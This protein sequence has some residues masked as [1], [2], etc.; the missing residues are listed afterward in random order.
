MKYL[1][2][3]LIS[4]LILGQATAQ[5][6]AWD[7]TR[8]KNWPAG[9][10]RIQITASAD[11][12]PQPC[13]VYRAS[14]PNQ[15]LVVSL[16]SWSGDYA[17]ADSL[18]WEIR[19]RD[20]NYIHPHF[21]GPNWTS[22]ACGS[23]LVVQD[24]DDAIRFAIRELKANP[25]EVHVVGAS[26]GG[27]AAMLCYLQLTYP[28]KSISSWVGISSLP[29][30]YDESL[31]RGQ[32]YA[33]D[34]L[35]ATGD[36]LQLNV[37]EAQKRSPLNVPMA[38]QAAQRQLFLY[39]GIHDGYQGS[40]P[41]TQTLRFYNRVVNERFPGSKSVVSE[42]EM[43]A[44]VV[45]RIGVG[46]AG[47]GS[48]SV[49]RLGNRKVHFFRQEGNVSTTIFDGKH[50]Q[51]VPS[52]LALLP[53]GNRQVNQA[54]WVLCI[55]DS[56]GEIK[57]GWVRQ[58]SF[59]WPSAQ[60]INKC[61]SGN[62]IGFDNNGNTGL[63]EGKNIDRH[64]AEAAAQTN[65]AAI[66]Y[67]VVALGTN[68]TKVDFASR[69]AEVAPN[70]E[71]LLLAIKN[72]L[73]PAIKNARIV[74]LSPPPIAAEDSLSQ[75]NAQKYAGATARMQTLQTQLAAV[76]RKH[77]VLFINTNEQLQENWPTYSYDGIHLTAPG[78]RVVA[79]CI[80]NELLNRSIPAK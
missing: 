27:H 73:L 56:N 54:P 42:A 22:Q 59:E 55:G 9:F 51:V 34:I 71:R 41:I 8:T 29:D 17:Q 1:V 19:E 36:T 10:E 74:L 72:S 43:L 35:K 52:V 80:G 76:A 33:K 53:V 79:R 77:N 45:K 25:S 12:S 65:G 3:L 6:V 49:A 13:M 7:D 32:R 50:E 70:M 26:G 5:P 16:H 4:C 67:V 78:A 58:L 21:R 20:W 14:Q 40:V 75:T 47:P 66:Q 44:M 24:I 46:H 60:I 37:A 23:T 11:N 48:A 15:P 57:E 39:A 64:L 28:V 2:F 69:Q 38:Q 63:N 62:T 31:G 68:D 18:S 61:K 30:W